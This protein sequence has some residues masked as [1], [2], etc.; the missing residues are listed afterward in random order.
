MSGV[1]IG[2]L[3]IVVFLALMFLGIP[4]AATMALCGV[5]GAKF[6]LPSWNACY[7]L[8]SNAFIFVYFCSLSF[9]CA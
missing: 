7:T 5:V 2:V 1:L 8:F 9:L 4:I 3:T 6:F